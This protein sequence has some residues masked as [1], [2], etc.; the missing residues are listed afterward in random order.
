MRRT[1]L[2]PVCGIVVAAFTANGLA[3]QQDYKSGIVWPEPKIVTPGER[4][5]DPPADAIVLFDGK[6][7]SKWKNGDKWDVKDGYAIVQKSDI[8]TKDSF[9]DYQLHV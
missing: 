9:G 1:R 4:P 3:L 8:T 5:G 7:L 2:L 6:D